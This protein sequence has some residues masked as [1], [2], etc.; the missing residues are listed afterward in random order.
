M[1]SAF[2][3]VV[4]HSLA[5]FSG[6][7]IREIWIFRSVNEVHY[8]GKEGETFPQKSMQDTSVFLSEGCE[9]EVSYPLCPFF[10]PLSLPP[11]LPPSLPPMDLNNSL[12]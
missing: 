6:F 3:V 4:S 8:G 5:F 1:L 2:I 7:T 11:L 12:S 10:L 9:I